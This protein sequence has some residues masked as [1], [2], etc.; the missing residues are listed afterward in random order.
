MKHGRKHR[1]FEQEYLKEDDN[2]NENHF[3]I[4]DKAFF[5]CYNAS[6]FD[7]GFSCRRKYFHNCEAD[8]VKKIAALLLASA[9]VLSVFSGCTKPSDGNAASDS[10]KITIVATI[11]PAYDWVKNV[12]GTHTEEAE[13]TLLLDNGVDLHSFQPTAEDILKISTCDFFIYVGGESDAWVEKALKGTVNKEVKVISLMDALGDAVKEE[14]LVEGMQEEEHEEEHEEEEEGP[15]TDEHVWLSLRNAEVLVKAIAETLSEIDAENAADYNKNA[16]SYIEKLQALDKE[17]EKA[18]REGSTNTVLFADRFP[19]R[20][21]VDDYGLNYFAAFAGCSAEA[22][23]SFSTIT[24]L[25]GKLDELQ[26]PAVLVLEG[27][28][29]RIAQTVVDNTSSK[30]CEILVMNSMQGTSSEDIKAG[31]S[32]LSIME[33]NLAVLK[34]SLGT[35]SDD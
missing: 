15:E 32:Y 13:L 11:F 5:L 28:D 23:A 1:C 2:E 9:V 27:S 18:V 12:L 19:F 35:G 21:L 29:R 6:C 26:L 4:I 22:E 3:H 17:Y 30:D 14:E 33:A 10:G 25:S 31:A 24:F 7:D 16:A 8:M 20:Y 34:S